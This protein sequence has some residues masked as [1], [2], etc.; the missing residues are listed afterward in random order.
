M[1]PP[2]V[3]LHG[4]GLSPAVFT[5]LRQHL[6]RFSRIFTPWLP[7]HG[8][9]EP[10]H[11]DE[12]ADWTEMLVPDLPDQAVLLGWSLGGMIALDLARR[13]P[14]KVARLVL[15][16]TTP[17]FVTADDWPH[18][19]GPDVVQ[20]FREGFASEP[21]GTLRRFVA[22]QTLGDV[23]RK[24]VALALSASLAPLDQSDGGAPAEGLRLLA[25]TDLRAEIGTIDLPTRVLHGRHDALMPAEAAVWLADH[26]PQGRLTIFEDAAHAPFLSRPA[27]F[28]TLIDGFADE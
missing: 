8:A 11:G 9:Q 23:R 6:P 13:H 7:G 25:E 4:W 14:R 26:L 22:L 17:C 3:L 2:L 10:A 24:A 27:E 20:G 28:A 18:G 21:A 12:L 19:L 15:V 16:G 1:R 5:G